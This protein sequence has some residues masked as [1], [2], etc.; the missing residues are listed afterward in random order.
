MDGRREKRS[1]QTLR[2]L[3]SSGAQPVVAEYAATENVSS[4][5]VRVRTERPWK[6]DS[7]VL[8]KFSQGDLW[9]RARV[10]YCQTLQSKTFALGLEFLARTGEWLGIART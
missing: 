10:V 8:I 4:Y 1:A 6:P 5:G 3:L 2:V 9:A 7:R